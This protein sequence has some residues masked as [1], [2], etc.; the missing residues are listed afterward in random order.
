MMKQLPRQ[1]NGLLKKLEVSVEEK[2]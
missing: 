1:F 2:Q